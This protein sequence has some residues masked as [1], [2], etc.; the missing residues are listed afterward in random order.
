MDSWEGCR[1]KRRRKPTEL[2]G[3]GVKTCENR[4]KGSRFGT[5]L[6]ITFK[7]FNPNAGCPGR[8][9]DEFV[10]F[11]AS[12]AEP[13]SFGICSAR[14]SVWTNSCWSLLRESAIGRPGCTSAYRNLKFASRSDGEC[15]GVPGGRCSKVLKPGGSP[16]SSWWLD[17]KKVSKKTNKW[18]SQLNIKSNWIVLDSKNVKNILQLE[19]VQKTYQTSCKK[20]ITILIIIA[21]LKSPK[22][23]NQNY[24]KKKRK[25]KKESNKD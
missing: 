12:I 9:T 25:V 16:P 7:S 14:G 24:L 10:E 13:A 18:K 11:D 15:V 1:W 3:T 23:R 6:R 8:A 5:V 22:K 19:K 21:K 20:T 4:W 2:D 17:L